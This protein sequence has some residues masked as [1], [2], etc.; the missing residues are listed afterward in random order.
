MSFVVH[1]AL[2]HGVKKKKLEYFLPWLVVIILFL[3]T[4]PFIMTWK[5]FER[6]EDPDTEWLAIFIVAAG[7][8]WCKRTRV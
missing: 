4:G 2:Y 6:M 5:Y 3:I 1:T 7:Y 8:P